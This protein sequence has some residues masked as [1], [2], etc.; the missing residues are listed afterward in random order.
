MVENKSTIYLQAHKNVFRAAISYFVS[1]LL[2]SFI[3]SSCGFKISSNGSRTGS[4]ISG[5][6]TPFLGQIADTERHSFFLNNATAAAC[7]DPVYAKLYKL[8]A[9]GSINESSELSSQLIGADARYSFDI[10]S[11]GINS[12]NT[13]VEFIVK[14]EG[15]NGDVYKR[16]VTEFDSKQDI[17]AKSTVVAEV[18]NASNLIPNKLNEVQ[19]KKVE[20]LINSLEGTSTSTALN[21]LINNTESA[22]TFTAIFGSSPTVIQDSKPEVT[23]EIPTTA[24]NELAIANFKVSAF[25]VDPNYSFA[26]KWKYD[27]AIVGSSSTLNYIPSANESGNHQLVLY[28]GKNDG[29]GNIDLSKPYYTNTFNVVVNN[30]ILPTPPNFSLNSSTPSPRNT[31]TVQVDLNTGVSLSNCASFSKLAVTDTNQIPGVLQFNLSCSNSGT[32]TETIQFSSGDGAKTLY[33]WAM[34]NEGNISSAKTLSLILDTLPPVA[35]LTSPSTLVRGGTTLNIDLTATDAGVGLSSLDLYFS[36]DG[37]TSFSL[38]SHL[39]NNATTFS[40]NVPSINVQNAKLKLVATD[41]TSSSSSALSTNFEIDST[42]P[43]APVL[44]RTSNSSS[45]STNVTIGATCSADYFKILYSVSSA[46][47]ALSDSAWENCTTT[48]NFTVPSGDGAKTIYAF[49]RDVAGNIS[50]SSNVSMTLDTTSPSAPVANLTS[51]V[52]SSSVTAHFTVSDCLDRPSLFV[53]EFILAPSASDSGW[54]VCSTNANAISYNLLGPVLQGTHTLYVYAKD[55]VG[56]ISAATTASM[57]YDTTNPALS[58]S[59][60]LSSLYKGGDTINFN[61]SSSDAN[62]LSSLKLYFTND[63]VN[64]SLVNSLATTATTY[65]F[66][67]PTINTTTAKLKLVAIDN[68]TTANETIVFSNGFAIDSTAPVASTIARTSSQYS[69]SNVVTISATCSSDFSQI[70][71]SESSVTPALGDTHWEACTTTKSFTTTSDDGV[72]NIYAFTRDLAGNISTSSNVQMTLDTTLPNLSLTNFSSGGQFQGGSTQ[73][74]SW[75]A[76]DTNMVSTPIGLAYSTDGINFTTIATNLLNNGS[77]TWTLPLIDSNQVKIRL[78]AVDAAGNQK[79]VMSASPFTIDSSAPVLSSIVINDGA[80]YAGTSIVNIKVNVADNFSSSSQIYLH[81]APANVATSDCQSEFTNDNWTQY[82]SSTTS[83]L[84]SIVPTDGTKKI[85]VWAKDASGNISIM[86]SPSAG[87]AGVTFDTIEYQ[88]GTPPTISFFEVKKSGGSYVAAAGDPMTISWTATDFE[89][90]AANAISFSYTT[91]NITWKDI[92]T[93]LSISNSNNITWVG[94]LAPGTTTASGSFTTWVAPSS[95]YFRLKAQARD[96]AG[97]TSNIVM[98]QPINTGRWSVY[99]GNKDRGNGGTGRAAVLY[100]TPRISAFAINPKN[101]DVYA[102]DEGVG[103]RKLDAKTGLVSTFISSG[104]LNLPVD[105]PLPATPTMPIGAYLNPIFDSKGRL[106]LAT[107]YSMSTVTI[108]QIDIENNYVRKY[109]GGGTSDD[110]GVPSTSL[111]VSSSSMAFDESDSLYLFTVIGMPTTTAEILSFPK[112]LI[113][114]TQNTDGSPG[115]TTRIIGGGTAGA[116]T[117]GQTAYSQPAS[118]ASNYTEY[119]GISAWDNGQKILV[120]GYAGN[121]KYKIINGVVYSTNLNANFVN[122]VSIYNPLDGYVYKTTSTGGVEKVLINSNG[123]NGEVSTVLFNGNATAAGCA[124]DGT[125]TTNFCGKIDT[126]LQIRSGIL[127]FTDGVS[128]NS[129]SNYSIRYFDSTNK[130][131]TLFGSKPFYGDGQNRSV[132]RGNFAAIYYKTAAEPESG[133][134]PEGLYFMESNGFVF[135]RINTDD[136]VTQLWGNQARVGSTMVDGTTVS[137]NLNLGSPYSG[138]DGMI[139]TFDNQGHPWIRTGLNAVKIDGQNKIVKMT[140][141]STSSNLQIA[142][143]NANPSLYGLWV[144]SGRS[145]FTLKNQG[146]F[147]TPNYVYNPGYDPAITIRYMDFNSL[148]TPILIGANYLASSNAA[149][150]ADVTTPGQVVNAPLWTSCRNGTNCFLQYISNDDR[151]YF[152]ENNKLRYITT[153]DNPATSTLVTLFTIPSG[154]IYNFQFTPDFSQLWYMRSNGGLFCY[155][156]T[157]GRSWCD[158][159]TDHFSIRTSAGFAITPGAN[160]MTF[161]DNQTMF[162]ST[163]S[164]EILQFALPTA[165]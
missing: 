8:Q 35:S 161:K 143:N 120:I 121:I 122:G 116:I 32:Q 162:I 20:L 59:A 139:M 5:I 64:Y 72:K 71:Y 4:F 151:L 26:Y 54:Q 125:A 127:Y 11:L 78:T 31:N 61:F 99:A 146:L 91:D 109:A 129:G 36:T 18:I 40:W 58:L 89:E 108:Y 147:V 77:Y 66:S 25:H 85:C 117:S 110:E 149:A 101:G 51:P 50:N 128:N 83:F 136:T 44:T 23:L 130:L 119:T 132:A 153:P 159:T 115:T 160:Q 137:K 134:F 93:N 63:D 21:S 15:C 60:T 118:S 41:L 47:P 138:G 79:T 114:V 144:H 69:N 6:V 9:D 74:I 95:S 80:Q 152:S 145:N 2:L 42:A 56:N 155:D 84:F 90:L 156:L 65:A 97:N 68:S 100:G 73:N 49:T 67:V 29:S 33:L 24:I 57:I 96:V 17:S 98:S 102:Y 123:A 75:S 112:R 13:N 150:S 1:L 154:V 133:A 131:Q 38:V 113:K 94:N 135:G 45:N 81:L 43:T 52:I 92:T 27:G 141:S 48:K 157:S 7:A 107:N 46:I 62:G 16:P 111:R 148:T 106:Y 14:A 140:T 37:G 55:S 19:R 105:G 104:T 164:G 165:P 142:P 124:D 86:N 82:Q 76:T 30:N 163:F 39:A 88:T 53:S 103:I 12:K 22:N 70:L 158:N 87:V 10:K 34:D 126:S 3:L 28:L